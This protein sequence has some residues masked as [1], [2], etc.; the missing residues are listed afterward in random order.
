MRAVVQ[1]VREA[2]VSVGGRIC[3]SIASGLLVYLGVAQGDTEADAAYL[4]EKIAF[5]RIFTDSQGKM[6]L[7]VQDTGGQILAVSQ[8]TLLADARKGRRPS[9]SEAAEPVLAQSLYEYFM[10]AIREQ[11][12][13]CEAG[14]FQAHMEV[15]YTNDGPVTILLDS[16][17]N[18]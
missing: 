7:S 16:R 5:L 2:A 15:T 11:G 4:A 9:Y 6:N 18:F 3:G 13:P 12:I 14:I 1:R 8:F 10:A 17:K